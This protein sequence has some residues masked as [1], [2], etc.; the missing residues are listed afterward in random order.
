MNKPKI[1]LKEV[2]TI[3]FRDCVK[4]KVDESQVAWVATN[5]QSLA[6]A[7]VNKKLT[8]LAIYDGSLIV[9]DTT[10]EHRMVGFL[11]YQVWDEVGFIMRL[12]IGAEHQR[13]GYARAAMVEVIRRLRLIPQVRYIGTS[14]IPENVAANALYEGLGF[15]DAPWPPDDPAGERYMMLPDASGAAVRS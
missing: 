8:P 6:Q 4:L 10:P 13:K 11:M 15:V 14:V 3:N 5:T 12:M 1:S 9:T 2:N 7:Y